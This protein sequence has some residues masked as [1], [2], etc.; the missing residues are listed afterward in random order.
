ML[1]SFSL[2]EATPSTASR[3]QFGLHQTAHTET[4]PPIAVR[5]RVLSSIAVGKDGDAAVPTSDNTVFDAMTYSPFE[6]A[7]ALQVELTSDLANQR[8]AELFP[9]GRSIPAVSP[10][11]PPVASEPTY[12][13]CCLAV[14]AGKAGPR[15]PGELAAVD[16]T[17]FLVADWLGRPLIGAVAGPGREQ[18]MLGQSAEKRAEQYEQKAK[19]IRNKY[20]ALKSRAHKA[21]DKCAEKA[22][23]LDAKV[24]AIEADCEKELNELRSQAVKLNGLPTTDTLVVPCRSGCAFTM[25]S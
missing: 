10:K 11:L 8:V 4:E 15:I 13:L 18:L 12:G 21:A 20:S 22:A 16:I 2:E 6:N 7:N 17:G 19:S 1:D 3:F 5:A 14:A 25:N 9:E 23:G 24:R